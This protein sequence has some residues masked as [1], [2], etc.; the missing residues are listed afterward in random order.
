MM[1]SL[2]FTKT[3]LS[4]EM[5]IIIGSLSKS[6]LIERGVW[7]PHW[8]PIEI[9]SVWSIDG[10]SGISGQLKVLSKPFQF[11]IMCVPLRGFFWV[12]I[13]V[14]RKSYVIMRKYWIPAAYRFRSVKISLP[15]QLQ[16]TK[17]ALFVQLS[18]PGIVILPFNTKI[19][20]RTNIIE[21]STFLGRN[22]F[23]L[24][25]LKNT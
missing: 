12:R 18:I 11:Q 2:A 10:C 8:T 23:L 14:F 15:F 13:R 24:F 9:E 16:M 22:F 1:N 4:F 20:I 21:V 7:K 25:V 6:G 19:I 5:P 17:F 3:D